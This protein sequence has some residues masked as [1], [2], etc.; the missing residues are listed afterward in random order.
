MKFLVPILLIIWKR[1]HTTR[2][3]IDALREIYPT[4]IYL[5]C[6]GPR[7]GVEGEAEKVLSTRSLAIQSIDW[8]CQV[9]IR[10][11]DINLGCRDGVSSAVS[12]FFQQVP[13]GIVLEDDIV[14]HLEFFE[15]C[16]VCLEHYR[17]DNRIWA[18]SGNCTSTE[19]TILEKYASTPLHL[20]YN[21]NC[22]GWASWCDRWIHYTPIID[23][24]W[25]AANQQTVQSFCG[26][27]SGEE[28]LKRALLGSSRKIDTWDYQVNAIS[29]SRLQ[30]TI[31]PRLSLIKNIGFGPDATH[32]FGNLDAGF[33]YEGEGP[34]CRQTWL[35][36]FKA[37][38]KARNSLPPLIREVSDLAYSKPPLLRRL[39]GALNRLLR[40]FRIVRT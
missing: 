26:Q 11:S 14:P 31:H 35:L 12:W 28:V 5:A 38:I 36:T 29:A 23:E 10:F 33:F 2:C 20:R 22:W 16:R 32:T 37:F 34:Q 9:S 15:Y 21:F 19:N 18:I 25:L 40:L 1:P 24:A 7:A 30:Y 4:R 13:E 6:D 39:A 8:E 3:V 27:S 17:H